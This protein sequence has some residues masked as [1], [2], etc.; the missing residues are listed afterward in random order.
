MSESTRVILVR[1]AEPHE[2]VRGRAYG[3]LDV[4]LSDAGVEHT[5]RLAALLAD[6]PVAAVYSSSLERAV[7]TARP[8]AAA[9]ELA[10]EVLDDLREL[11]FGE[12][13]GLLIEEVAERYPDVIG[14]TDDPDAARFPG[15]ETV[16]ALRVRAVAAV[17]G[18]VARHAG[19]TVVVVSHAIAIR[20]IL[21]DALG[22]RS[23]ALFRIDQAYGGIT[24]IDW[25]GERPLIRGVN[26]SSV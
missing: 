4:G 15:G 25:F 10:I 19:E 5:A 2:S 16:P 13:E 17:R 11:D 18:I 21:A 23:D 24:T 12:L 7:A 6:I 8:I 9:H 22:M 1:H 26:V 20:A 3:R 14:W